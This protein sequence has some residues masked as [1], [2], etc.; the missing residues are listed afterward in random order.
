MF[1]CCDV[2]KWSSFKFQLKLS[3][4]EKQQALI[5]TTEYSSN[6]KCWTCVINANILKDTVLKSSAQA[7]TKTG[8]CSNEKVNGAS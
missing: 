3:L 5:K 8:A 2:V 7:W 4:I 6:G 1:R